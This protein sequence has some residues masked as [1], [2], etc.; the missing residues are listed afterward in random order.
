MRRAPRRQPDGRDSTAASRLLSPVACRL[1]RRPVAT[2]STDAA[3]R[4]AKRGRIAGMHRT[5]ALS[6]LALVA[7]SMS[8]PADARPRRPDLNTTFT[9]DETDEG[10]TAGIADYPEGD[11]AGYALTTDHAPLPGRLG[12]RSSGLFVGSDNGSDDLF[13]FVK[14]RITGLQPGTE[15]ELMIDVRI[16]S[17]APRRVGDDDGRPGDDVFLKA[18]A[19]TLEPMAVLV[20]GSMRLNAQKG[21]TN[22]SGGENAALLGNIGVRTR[23]A[24]PTFR[25]K[26]LLNRRSPV[27][28]VTD[29]EGAFWLLVG[30]D[31]DYAGE[32]TV[33]YDRIRVRGFKVAATDALPAWT[34]RDGNLS[35]ATRGKRDGPRNHLGQVTAYYFLHSG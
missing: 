8:A 22:D 15:Y 32:T 14:R 26:R 11:T 6:A 21:T 2:P 35:S 23:A 17:Q 18:G 13:T 34:L 4:A 5:L 30:T 7:L 1:I 28:V 27:R 33:C 19:T 31:S 16:L 3:F 24:N 20:D 10:F 29:S 12:R 25:P 9:F